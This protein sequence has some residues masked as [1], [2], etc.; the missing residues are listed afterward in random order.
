MRGVTGLLSAVL[1][2]CLVSIVAVAEE[3]AEVKELTKAAT[4]ECAGAAALTDGDEITYTKIA[5]GGSVNITTDEGI[6]SLYIIFDR[7]YGEW[8]LSDGETEVLCGQNNFLH[9]YVD[10]EELFGYLP[11]SL[12]MTFSGHDC[13]LSELH[14]FGGSEVPAW[15]QR[16]EPPCEEADLM[17]VSTHIDDEQLFFAGILPYYA[18]EQ[19]LAVQVV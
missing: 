1:V 19:G 17:L 12:T 18:G 14:I 7:I 8:T 5:D 11:M 4:I 3:S 2:F 6:A 10:V 15:V 16:W 13:Q 9:E